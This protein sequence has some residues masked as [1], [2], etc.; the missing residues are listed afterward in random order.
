MAIAF[1]RSASA[2]S[3]SAGTTLAVT[4]TVDVGELVVVIF[5][6]DN[7]TGTYSCADN[8]SNAYTHL[9]GSL[10]FS[11]SWPPVNTN[12]SELHC[13]YLPNAPAATSVTVTHPSLTARAAWVSTYTGAATSS[14]LDIYGANFPAGTST[15]QPP[16]LGTQTPSQ[17]GCLV[18]IGSSWETTN[19][20]T[21]TQGNSLLPTTPESSFSIGTTGG[22]G[23]S[24]QVCCWGYQIQT[25]A[26]SVD[27]G[28]TT[29]SNFLQTDSSGA[30]DGAGGVIVFKP[31]AGAAAE[32]PMPFIGGG[33]YG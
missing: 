29:T 33:Y 31:D 5:A 26:A 10:S 7:T 28:S 21:F 32:D 25:T 13:F 12:G 3:K 9:T 4:I 15:T 22:G 23:A 1:H 17:D 20:D 16:T 8:N 2:Q 18:I 30:V 19:N 24:N 14:P 11:G 27:A 6:C